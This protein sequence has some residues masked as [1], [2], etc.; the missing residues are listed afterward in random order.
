M[1]I[2]FSKTDNIKIKSL[3]NTLSVCGHQV[4]IW[5]DKIIPIADMLYR[6]KIDLLFIE[7]D[8]AIKYENLINCNC[9]IYGIFVPD[10]LLDKCKL[11]IYDKDIKKSIKNNINFENA[12]AID[13]AADYSIYRKGIFKEKYKSDVLYFSDYETSEENI[14]LINRLMYDTS[15]N[16]ICVGKHYIPVPCYFGNLFQENRIHFMKSTKVVLN[17]SKQMFYNSSVNKICSSN[18]FDE[19]RDLVHNKNKRE[20]WIKQN[21]KESIENHTYFHRLKDIFELINLKNESEKCTDIFRR[22]RF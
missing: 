22:I 10:K 12:Y 2:V 3:I 4:I 5:D 8:L 14:E 21:Y 11:L 6:N 17:L 15:Y 7:T 20:A 19:I 18:N 13:F 9:I 1:N 16:F